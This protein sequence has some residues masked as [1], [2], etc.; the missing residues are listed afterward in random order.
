[1]RFLNTPEGKQNDKDEFYD[2]SSHNNR[3]S[4]SSYW[5]FSFFFIFLFFH[6]LKAGAVITV[7]F[8]GF[9]IPLGSSSEIISVAMA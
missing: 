6:G 3:V 5:T 7:P 4:D 8:A 9:K 1:M 2:L